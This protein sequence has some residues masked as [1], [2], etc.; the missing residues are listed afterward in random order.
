VRWDIYLGLP[1]IVALETVQELL[2]LELRTHPNQVVSVE[3][4]EV[5]DDLRRV[6]DNLASDTGRL[7]YT[8]VDRP[9]ECDVPGEAHQ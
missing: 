1:R 8:V 3:L 7:T 6:L 5:P 9:S 2:E 4:S